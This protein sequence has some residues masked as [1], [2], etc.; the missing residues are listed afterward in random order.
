MADTDEAVSDLPLTAAPD[1]STP[2]SFRVRG[3]QP[4]YDPRRNTAGRIKKKPTIMDE[5]AKQ[6][7]QAKHR[8]KV[9]KAWIDTAE[10][11][12]T[13]AGQRAREAL[14]DRLYGLPKQTLVLEQG[15]SEYSA[16]LRDL[17]E[18]SRPYLED[19]ST[20]DSTTAGGSVD[21]ASE[22]T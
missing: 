10:E 8:R 2:D 13:A 3:F 4:G 6:A 11:P 21:T 18:L 15:E 19:G 16:L 12:H 5:L 9:A 7:H 22:Q 17:A 1:N 14:T 20:D